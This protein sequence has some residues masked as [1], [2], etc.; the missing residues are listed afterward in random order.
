MLR[1]LHGK[2][3][4]LEQRGWLVEHAMLFEELTKLNAKMRDLWL[5]ARY[6]NRSVQSLL[7][8]VQKAHHEV[9]FFSEIVVELSRRLK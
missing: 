6:F 2:I 7:E 4:R 9:D 3:N 1:D 5:E 8:E